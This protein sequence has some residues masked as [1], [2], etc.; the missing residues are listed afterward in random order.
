MTRVAT[1]DFTFEFHTE[2]A[3]LSDAL[4][5]ELRSEAESQL[6]SLAEGH[7]DLVGASVVLEE[8]ARAESAFLYQARVVVYGRPDHVA[9]VEKDE[10]LERALR[11]A[12]DAVERQ[13]QERRREL[14]ER[15]KQP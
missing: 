8:P 7:T 3:D 9:A 2:I 12:L 11:G 1:L 5:D 10:N 15:W 4:E 14:A 6:L 13:V